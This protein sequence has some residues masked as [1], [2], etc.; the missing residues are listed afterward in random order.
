MYDFGTG[1]KQEI[2][3]AIAGMSAN[4]VVNEDKT[5]RIFN[6]SDEEYKKLQVAANL[7]SLFDNVDYYVG[8]TY[9]DYGQNW[10]WTTIL[11]KNLGWGGNTQV[12]SPK[13]QENIIFADSLKA[14]GD[15]VDKVLNKKPYV[16]QK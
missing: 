10:K 9:F 3:E 11:K 4:A 8:E 7:L 15:A 13:D 6:K 5:I 12:L 16:P 1:S 2:R 14:L